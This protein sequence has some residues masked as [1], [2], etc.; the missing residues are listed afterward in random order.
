MSI[1]FKKICELKH[2]LN[3]LL[4]NRPAGDNPHNRMAVLENLLREQQKNL[5]NC[6]KEVEQECKNIQRLLPKVDKYE[7]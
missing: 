7:Q 6:W 4:R 2:D 5:L 1:D 3:E